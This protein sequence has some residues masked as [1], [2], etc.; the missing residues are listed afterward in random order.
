MERTDSVQHGDRFGWRRWGSGVIAWLMLGASP[1]AAAD[2]EYRDFRVYVD[3]KPAGTY[4]MTIS[5][6]DD[7]SFIM[8]AQADVA[9]TYLRIYHYTY[10]FRGTETWKD[11][12]LQ[13]LDSSSNDD[14]KRFT[15]N[16]T[17]DGNRLRIIANNRETAVRPEA[18]TTTYW[19]LPDQRYRNQPLT[20]VDADTGRAFNVALQYL[21]LNNVN[22]AGQVRSCSHYHVSGGFKADVWFDD[23]ERLVRVDTVDDGHAEILELIRIRR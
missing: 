10:T 22:V 1:L 18:W 12:L 21:G 23:Q 2:I 7:G 15:V 16:A 6:Q 14:G 8:S 9:V 13:R 4:S 20:L 17:A 11:G 5:R 3:G 19:R